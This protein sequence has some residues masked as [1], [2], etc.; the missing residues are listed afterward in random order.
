MPSAHWWGHPGTFGQPLQRGPDQRHVTGPGRRLGQLGHHKGPVPSWSRSNARRAASRAASCRPRPLYSTD[1]RVVRKVDQSAQTACGRLLHGGLDQLRRLVLLGPAMPRASSR[2]AQRAGFRSPP[3][4]GDLLRS[5]AP[6]WPA[7]PRRRWVMARKSSA[8]CKCTSAPVSRANWAWR[9]ARVCQDSASHSSRAMMPLVRHRRARA[10]GRL[11]R[12][13]RPEREPARVPG[14]TPVRPRAYPSVS[15]SASAS[16][17]TSTARG[18][19]GPGGAVRAASAASRTPPGMSRSPAHIAAPERLQ[20]RLARQLGVERLEPSGRAEQQ[21]GGVAAAALVQGDL[22]AQVAPPRRACSASSGPAST[23]TSS[24]SAASS[25]PAS[26]LARAAASSRSRPTGRGRVSASPRAP[27]TR[28]PRPAPR[29]PAP[30]RPSARAPRRP[31]HRARRGLRPVPGAAV[32]I[33][34]GSVT[35]ASAPCTSCRSRSDADR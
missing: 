25:A 17:R 21:P 4:S 16:S 28:P 10:S 15:R 3:R 29:A 13:R 12:R 11:R 5:A 19:S 9:A 27:G 30:G 20:V 34:R 24:P 2:Y 35:S 8:N 32:R 31:P 6:L 1:A 18:G 22:P 23:A 26:R 7:P 14:S 33:G